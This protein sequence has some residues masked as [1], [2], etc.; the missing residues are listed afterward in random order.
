MVQS[1]DLALNLCVLV[2]GL[3]VGVFFAK[4]LVTTKVAAMVVSQ[5][6]RRVRWLAQNNAIT[7]DN[8]TFAEAS[9]RAGI[10]F[11]WGSATNCTIIL[12]ETLNQTELL[13]LLS[14]EFTIG[15]T[16]MIH[17]MW[18]G[19]CS[20]NDITWFSKRAGLDL[21][22]FVHCVVVVL[23]TGWNVSTILWAWYGTPIKVCFHRC[24]RLLTGG[25]AAQQGGGGAD[26]KTDDEPL[27]NAA[28]LP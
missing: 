17:T 27:L 6:L 11:S 15:S 21:M 4:Q 28:P 9:W 1:E 25:G 3:G 12:T 22:C 24:R 16:R 2:V 19:E 5:T 18:N 8:S 13:T 20:L 7:R 14:K 26:K 10:M 23:I